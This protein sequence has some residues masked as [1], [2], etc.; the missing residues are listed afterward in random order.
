VGVLDSTERLLE[1][2]HNRAVLCPT[3][4]YRMICGETF[5]AKPE[6]VLAGELEKVSL[7][8]GLGLVGDDDKGGW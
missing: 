6:N 7:F 5:G 8:A 4:D 1:D 3:C 2:L